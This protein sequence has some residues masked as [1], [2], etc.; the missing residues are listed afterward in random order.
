VFKEGI[1]KN[2]NNGNFT[3]WKENYNWWG[4]SIR[5]NFWRGFHYVSSLSE[6]FIGQLK[7]NK[8]VPSFHS[9]T[10]SSLLHRVET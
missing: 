8:Y 2:W 4:G 10:V 3:V 1:G 5:G 6:I 9:K 7:I